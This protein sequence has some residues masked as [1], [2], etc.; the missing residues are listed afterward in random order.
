LIKATKLF[1]FTKPLEQFKT[2][3]FFVQKQQFPWSGG[4]EGVVPG[5]SKVVAQH[6]EGDF[7]FP[8]LQIRTGNGFQ[9]TDR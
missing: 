9:E 4:L 1:Q 6:L 3:I 2:N 7:R 8:F 5:S